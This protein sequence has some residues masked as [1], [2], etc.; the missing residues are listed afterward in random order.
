M[1]DHYGHLIEEIAR[2]RMETFGYMGMAKK[3]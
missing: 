3:E 1:T 2:Q